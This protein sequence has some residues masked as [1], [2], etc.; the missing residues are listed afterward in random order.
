LL[1]GLS[2]QLLGKD[3]DSLAR[4]IGDPL[5]V[6]ASVF[7][8][9]L[10]R[11]DQRPL[12]IVLDALDQLPLVEQER[13]ADWLPRQLPSA[14]Q[15]VVSTTP[16][17]LQLSTLQAIPENSRVELG[18][19]DHADGEAMQRRVSMDDDAEIIVSGDKA[20]RPIILRRISRA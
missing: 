2:K 10:R 12:R 19:L 1:D 7:L 13:L 3:F 11:P 20:G 6:S 4:P 18:G 8:G 15:M 14:V 17:L 5:A 16:P 9:A